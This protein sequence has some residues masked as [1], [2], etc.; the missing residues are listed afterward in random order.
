MG[1]GARLV[2]DRRT[3]ERPTEPTIRLIEKEEASP[4]EIRRLV[5]GIAAH[6]TDAL[7]DPGFH[8]IAVFA[9]DETGEI[10]GGVTGTVNWTW[11]S[12]KLL[13]VAPE[14]RGCGLGRRL[15]TAI[16]DLGRRRGCRRAHV[17]TLGF[18]APGFYE[19]L[20]YEPFAELPDYAPGHPRVYLRKAL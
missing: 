12:I 10:V 2:S 17:D 9:E 8:P 1:E 13:W 15:M 19:R 5:D 4:E 14:L 16:E 6:A 20:G 18:Q 7:D 3:S 11:L